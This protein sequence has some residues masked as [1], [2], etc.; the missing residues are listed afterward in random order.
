MS[1]SNLVNYTK[2]SPNCN[3]PRKNQIDTVTIHCVVGQL[4][5]EQLGDIFAKP[6]RKA[7]SNYGIGVDGRIGLY[8][9]E[10]DR[11]WCSSNAA[12]DN[13]AVTIEVASD[14]KDPYAVNDK[15]MNSLITLLADICKR[16]GIKQLIWSVNKNDRVNH[17]NGCNMTVHRD[18]AN[19][20]CPGAYLY[21]KHGWIAAQVNKLLQGG[22]IMEKKNTIWTLE[23]IYN[24]FRGKGLTVAGTCGLLGNLY[25]ESGIR[26]NNLQ[27]SF[28][29]VLHM[30]DV[31]YTNAVNNGS[32]NRE[33]F[34]RD[35]AGYGIAQWTYWTRKQDLYEYAR[36]CNHTID[37]MEMQCVFLFKELSE[38]YQGVLNVLVSSDNLRE[39]SNM[40][41]MNFEKPKVQDINVQNKRFDYSLSIYNKF[42]NTMAAETKTEL[43]KCP[44]FVKVETP[45]LNV[46]ELPGTNSDKRGKMPLGTF[47]IVEVESGYGS[48]LGWGRLKSGIGW[49]SLDYVTIKK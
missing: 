32:Y 39:C 6:E 7:S 47:T 30:S 42:N 3:H 43:P 36:Q 13:R 40:V 33:Q 41:L 49:I 27:N 2:L 26:S 28:E 16:N 18:Y 12:N 17:L 35:G 20:E 48:K 15:A 38:K 24:Y 4:S 31:E 34:C 19:K 44:F 21:G 46:R 25:A 37:S 14:T 8:V 23:Q 5:V 45:N 11:S 10:C 1:N 22:E 29:K 9:N